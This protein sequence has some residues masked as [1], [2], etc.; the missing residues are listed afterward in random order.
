MQ[1][2]CASWLVLTALTA[3]PSAP[4]TLRVTAIPEA[5]EAFRKGHAV[6][7]AWLEKK[8]GVPVELRV[9]PTYEEAVRRLVSREADL[10]WLGGVTT[11][12]A[13]TQSDGRVRPILIRAADREFRSYVIATASLHAKTLESL[14]GKRFTFGARSSTSGHIMP[15]FFLQSQGLVP[16]RFFGQ[17]SYSGDH[18]KTALEVAAGEQDCGA[19][20]YKIFDELV[21]SRA[22][23]PARVTIVWKS[24]PFTDNSWVAARDL[25][26]RVGAGTLEKVTRAFL[27]LDPT[28][29][30]D[31]QVLDVLAT[32][33]YVAALP[34]W[35]RSIA[36]ALEVIKDASR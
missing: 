22:V 10:G 20:N 5:T 12:Q 2:L 13:L 6:F 29:A 28:Q 4:R 9:A 21:A 7:S 23:D 19:V 3:Q 33:K 27:A 16:E 17:V 32:D 8:A 1:A 30:E 18:R 24:P 26:E 31:R 36:A 25:D 15:R 35:W 11:V 34:E 14:R